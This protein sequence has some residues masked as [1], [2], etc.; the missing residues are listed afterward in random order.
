MTEESRYIREI[1][2]EPSDSKNHEHIASVKWNTQKDSRLIL[3][4]K[5]EM[6]RWL[7]LGGGRLAFVKVGSNL[8]L[9]KVINPA[10]PRLP[11]LETVK[12]GTQLDNLLSLPRF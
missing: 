5:A 2:M 8:V 11:F 12:D 9:V 3:D 4:T 1:H 7:N 6:I 10:P